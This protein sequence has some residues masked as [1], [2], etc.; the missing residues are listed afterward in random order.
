MS[1]V[2]DAQEVFPEEELFIYHGSESPEATE[3]PENSDKEEDEDEAEADDNVEVKQYL[4]ILKNIFFE[5]K[6]KP[7][8]NLSQN[9]SQV[10]AKEQY[11]YQSSSK[12]GLDP[13]S[14][15]KQLSRTK[16]LH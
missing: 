7:E 2:R 4:H 3:T 16:K 8:M 13:Q 15:I 1:L 14:S 12:L 5:M 6:K 9:Q 10:G 11:L